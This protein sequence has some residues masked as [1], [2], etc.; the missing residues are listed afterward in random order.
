MQYK[1]SSGSD[2]DWTNICS[3]YNDSV[4]YKAASGEKAMIEGATISTRFYGA[5]DQKYDIRAVT[6]S[7]VGNEFVTKSSP[8]I[9]GVKT[10]NGRSCSAIS[11]LPTACWGSKTKSA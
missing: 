8:V 11:N 7:K 6:F 3:F 4:K 2:K 5:E 1:P 10:R 9:S